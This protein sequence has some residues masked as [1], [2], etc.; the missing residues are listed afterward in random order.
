MPNTSIQIPIQDYTNAQRVDANIRQ[1]NRLSWKQRQ[2]YEIADAIEEFFKEM[3]IPLTKFKKKKKVGD[4]VGDYLSNKHQNENE[5]R[6][7]EAE[8][9]KLEELGYDT[10]TMRPRL[11]KAKAKQ[12]IEAYTQYPEYVE[13]AKAYF[14]L[15]GGNKSIVQK[16]VGPNGEVRVQ[17][18]AHWY[19]RHKLCPIWNMRKSQIIRKKYREFLETYSVFDENT[20]SRQLLI[21]THTPVHMVLTLPH[22]N[23]EFENERF[24]ARKLLKHFHEMRRC[25]FF[26][27]WI[28]GGEY[29]LEIKRSKNQNGLHIHLHSFCFLKNEMSVNNFRAWLTEKWNKLTGA[30][31]C[32][33]ETLYY[34]KKGENGR[35]I[36]EPRRIKDQYG[37]IVDY[38]K[39]TEPDRQ[40][41]QRTLVPVMV[42]K[43]FY[44]TPESTIQEYTA[45]VMEC[46]KY[47]FKMDDYQRKKGEPDED[48]VMLEQDTWDV[49][50]MMDILNN[51]VN[52]RF[53]S[54]YGGFLKI[55]ELNF[56]KRYEKPEPTTEEEEIEAEENEVEETITANTDGVLE[57]S[58]NPFTLEL[59]ED[60]DYSICV[61][62]PSNLVFA[63]DIFGQNNLKYYRDDDFI[64]VD[65]NFE[66]KQ[67]I[68]AVCTNKLHEICKADYAFSRN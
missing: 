35:Y 19:S 7:F 4:N 65:K 37:W 60:K 51:S 15:K 64:E 23:G 30:I 47:H 32:H 67:I 3:N 55:E 22:K 49:P 20:H 36:T 28:F 34:Y 9:E 6:I 40:G 62:S 24:Y 45:G 31:F 29:G 14:T 43:K 5:I 10:S 1:L 8:K 2:A 44:I 42:R 13:L 61:I 38:E 58:I 39:T 66:L 53:Y 16:F 25:K 59:A 27:D 26:K 21:K 57:R 56:N 17:L 48:G 12:A 18:L 41:A 33:F 50:L 68:R 46:I 11:I 52:M 54:R 63:K